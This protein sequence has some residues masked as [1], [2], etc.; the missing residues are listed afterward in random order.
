MAFYTEWSNGSCQWC[1]GIRKPWVCKPTRIIS[2]SWII[3][4]IY[5]K[6]SLRRPARLKTRTTQPTTVFISSKPSTNI[7]TWLFHQED[8]YTCG[9]RWWCRSHSSGIAD[10]FARPYVAR[11]LLSTMRAVV[12]TGFVGGSALCIEAP[13]IT[14]FVMVYRTSHL[15]MAVAILFGITGLQTQNSTEP[16]NLAID[17]QHHYSCSENEQYCYTNTFASKTIRLAFFRPHTA[18][19]TKY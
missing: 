17:L 19:S 2:M 12:L 15:L 18:N 3:S 16:K 4:P 10:F 13:T 8:G 11:Q 7:S 14:G 1:L 9:L 5:T 6:K